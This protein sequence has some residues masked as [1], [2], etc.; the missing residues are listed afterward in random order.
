MLDW[1]L[2]K[3]PVE[4]SQVSD[5]VIKTLVGLIRVVEDLLTIIKRVE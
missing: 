5:K 4:Y 1:N 2:T 3:V